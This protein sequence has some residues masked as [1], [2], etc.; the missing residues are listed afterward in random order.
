MRVLPTL[1]LVA[2]L[3]PR[4]ALAESRDEKPVETTIALLTIGP[5]DPIWTRFGHTALMVIRQRPGEKAYGSKVYNYGA[6]DFGAPGFAWRFFRGTARF[7]VAMTGTF[8]QNVNAYAANNRAIY[9]QKLNLTRDQV[10]RVVTRLEHDA[11]PENREYVYHHLRAG[12]AT[13][14]RDLLDEATGGEIRRQLGDRIDPHPPR[15]YGRLGYAGD[16]WAEIANDLFMGRLHD[17]PQTKYFALYLPRLL[18]EYL[19]E[20][21]VRDPEGKKDLVPLAGPVQLLV[22]RR[23][24]P[25]TYGEGRTLIHLAYL[26]IVYLGIL[27]VLAVRAGSARPRR[28]GV[29][30]LSWAVPMGIAGAMMI[31]GA[32]FSTV[33]EGRVNELV[34]S[35]PA[36]DLALIWVGVRWVRGRPTAGKTLRVYALVRLVMVAGVLL[37]HA[38][39]VLYQ[40]PR[41]LVFL[42]LA[43][44]LILN[45]LVR[46]LPATQTLDEPVSASSTSDDQSLPQPTSSESPS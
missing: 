18:S 2:A 29:W 23:G 14:V 13:K 43:C 28:A 21:K 9:Y 31:F 8:N 27:G 16:V 32:L 44:T 1:A 12:C 42:A 46:R 40:E 36:T 34:L 39:G 45:L 24:P 10:R 7:F 38:V 30:L 26:L 22:D 11:R 25:A 37:G 20:V 6:A 5:G 41:V 33:I 3:A 17:A 4:A 35:F 19:R 15:I